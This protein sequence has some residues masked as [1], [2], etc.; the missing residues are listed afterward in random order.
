M[1]EGVLA[2]VLNRFLAEYVDGLNT[3]QLNIGIWSGDV[4][5]RNLR[6]KRTALD[7]FQLPLDVKEGYLGRLTLSIPWS[8]LKS[9]SVRVLVENV[10]LI[11]APRDVDA[12]CEAG[13]E[14]ARMQA[15]KLAKLAQSEL[16]ALPADKPGDEN[17]QKTE[18]FLSSLITRIVDNVQVTVRNIHVRY[19]DAL[20]NPA[21]PF[22]VG[23]T[24]AELS[25][26]STNEHWEPTFVHNS[27][28][29][30]HK[31][32]R[33]D[34]LSVYWDTN[35]TF[36]SASD[37]EEL[38]S[39]LNELL[40]TKDVVPTHQYILKP[41]SGVGKLVMRPKA[42]KEAPKMDAQLVFDQIGV[43]LDDE[44]YRE[45]LSI[46]NL[47]TLYGRQSQYRSLRPA[48]EDLEAN[49]AR[50]RLLFAI[51]AIVNEVHQRRR[52]WTWKH[53]AER[54]DMRRE[55]I[56]LFKI[57]V[58]DAPAQPMPNVWPS[59]MSPEDAEHLRML[60]QCLEYRD[61]RFFRSLARRELRRELAERGPLVQAAE[62]VADATQAAASGV[63]QNTWLGWLW[64][65][66]DKKDQVPALNQEQRKELYEAIDWDETMGASL[67]AALEDTPPDVV[68]LHATAKLSKGFLHLHGHQSGRTL[69]SLMYDTLQGELSQ[70]PHS[71]SASLSLGGICVEDA[72]SLDTQ[73]R[74][75]VR[76]TD[77]GNDSG[78]LF[79]TLFEQNLLDGRADSALQLRMRSTEVVY[80]PS[81]IE[82]IARFF[83]PPET[84]L[85]LIGALIDV[86]S[87][88]LEG[89]RRETRAGLENALENHRTVDLS[90]DVQAP[91]IVVPEDLS[92]HICQNLVLDAGH[93][94]V[95]SLLVSPEALSEVRAKHHRQYTDEDMR[96][97]EDLMYDRYFIKLEAAQLVLGDSYEASMRSIA[98]TE[99]ERHLHLFERINLSFTLHTSILPRAPNLTR[100][101]LTGH[102]PSLYIH[103]S[104]RK[105]RM[106][107]HMIMLAIP[108]FDVPAVDVVANERRARIAEQLMGEGDLVADDTSETV[109]SE[110]DDHVDVSTQQLFCFELV[111]DEVSGTVSKSGLPDKL[112]AEAVF[113]H[114]MLGVYIFSGKLQVDVTLGSLD[115]VDKVVDQAPAFRHMITSRSFE[116]VTGKAEPPERDA[117][118]L[119]LVQYVSV[120]SDAP[121]FEAYGGIE[122][123][124]NVELSTINIMVTRVSVL[125]V[126]DWIL[127]T[128]AGGD[129]PQ[130]A[131]AEAEAPAAPATGSKFRLKVKLSSVRVRLND[132]GALLSTLTLS[133]AT[134]ALLLRGSTMRLAARLGSLSLRDERERERGETDFA[135]LLSI[136]G[137][138]LVDFAME[139]FD[140]RDAHYPGYDTSLWLRCNTLKLMYIPEPFAELV[141]F[142]SKFAEMKAV[143]DAATSAASAQASHLQAQQ[144]MTRYDVLVR[145]PIVVMPRAMGTVDRLTAHL[146][147]LYA[148]NSFAPLSRGYT[149]TLDAGLRQIRL[150]SHMKTGAGVAKLSMLKDV[151]VALKLVQDIEVDSADAEADAPR[152]CR[153]RFSSELSHVSA[154][155][156]YEQYQLA[157]SILRKLSATNAA[158]DADAAEAESDAAN[159][160]AK[161]AP[162]P[163]AVP[164]WLDGEFSIDQVQLDLFDEHAKTP[165]LLRSSQLFQFK[166]NEM[167][168]KVHQA[169]RQHLEAELAIRSFTAT[170][171]RPSRE[172]HFREI[173]PA[174]T[175]DGQQLLLNYTQEADGDALA[176]VTIDSPKLIFSLDP[177]FA[178]VNFLA[179][180]EVES[181]KAPAAT[182]PS[183]R[184]LSFRVNIVE[185]RIILLSAP[186][187]SD[188]QAIV[189][190][191][192]QA[193]ISQQAVLALSMTRLG[194]FVW[195]MNAP[196]D[197]QR[198]LNDVDVSLTMD[199]KMTPTGQI[200]S[201]QV[202]VDLLLVRVTRS[203]LML[204][205]TVVNKAI[206][207]SSTEKAPV[208]AEAPAVPA[209]LA[210]PAP[211]APDKDS[212]E[213][214]FSREE[215]IVSGAGVQVMLISE[216]QMLPLLDLRLNAYDVKA[217]DWSAD[218]KVK[219]ALDVRLNNFNLASS[220]WEPM[221]EPWVLDVRYERFVTPPSSSF[222]LSSRKR[223]EMNVSAQM[224]ETTSNMLSL[225]DQNH[226]LREDA[227][228]MAPFRIR[229]RTGY[230]LS[231]WN[232]SN[233]A[234]GSGQAGSA[235][236][237]GAGA[238]PRHSA[239]RLEDGHDMPWM[240]GDWKSLRENPNEAGFNRLAVHVDSMPWERVRHIDVD[241]EGEYVMS[242]RPKLERVAH[243]LLCDVKLVNNVKVITFQSTFRVDN[244]ALIPLEVGVLNDEGHIGDTVL[245]IEP[246][247]DSALPILSAYY[248]RIRVRP[249]PGLGYGWSQEAVGWQ[250]LL[251]GASHTFTCP[252]DEANEAPFLFQA[253][254][255]CDAETTSAR[256]YPQVTL[257][258]RAPVEIEN[259][260]PY[261]VHYRLFDKNLNHNWASFLRRGGISPVHVVALQ[262][263]LLLSVDIEDSVYSPSE[264]AIIA[265]DNPDDFQV[266]HVLPLADASN[267][268][269]ELRLHYHTY[270]DSGG[271][272][273]VQ[274]YAPYIFLNQTQL[275]VTLKMRPWAGHTRMVAGQEASSED[276]IEAHEPRRPFLL[277]R[278]RERN[279]RFVVRVGDSA[280]SRPLSFDV[281]GSEVGVAIQSESGDRELQLGLDVEDGLGKFKLSKI[282]KLTPRYMVHNSLRETL[283]IAEDGGG[284]PLTLAPDALVPLHWLHV[285]STRHCVL[286]V[287]DGAWSA[288][289]NIDN[290]GKVYVRVSQPEEQL[291]LRLEVQISGPSIFLRVFPMLGPW[292]YLLRN[293]TEHTVAFMQTTEGTHDPKRYVLK[294]RSKMKYAWDYPAEQEKSL[295]LQINGTE[296]VV[297]IL[298]IGSLL[299]FRFGA[300]GES[301]GGVVSLDVRADGETHTLVISDYAEDKSN[302]KMTCGAR[303]D[304]EA[305]DVDTSILFAFN[306]ELEG[307]GIS[308]V[309]SHMIE[310][311]YVTFRGVEFSFSE[312]Q[313]TTAVN[314]I[315]KWIQI[316][317]QTVESLFP[318][319]LYPTIVP[320][321][322]KELEVHPT[323]QAS[324]I[325]SKDESHGVRHIKYASVLLQE[326]TAELDE[327]F[328]FAVY[329]FVRASSATRERE[330][331]ETEY[332]ENPDHVPEPQPM[333]VRADQIYIEILHLQP[334]ALNLSYM[335][336]DRFDSSDAENTRTLFAFF[337]NMLTM[338]LGNVNEAPVR[339][340]ALV[341]ENVR[342]SKTVLSQRITYHYG[343]E[344]LFQVHR[345]LG[346]ADF[347]GN[348][349]GLFNNVSSGVAD[350]FYEPYYGLVMHGNRELGYGIARGASNFVKKTVFGVT[351]SV[352]KL[353]GSISKG[354]AAVTLDREFQSRWR[355]T[356][357]RN[358]PKHALYGI[359]SGANS[360]F[361]SVASGIEGLALRPLEGA[362]E[363]GASGFIQGIGRG[364]VGA[365]TKP[366]AGF[367]DMASSIT[368]GLRNTTLVF[369][370]NDIVRVRLP[371]FIANDHILRPYDP[372]EALGQDW[373][374]AVDQGR[375]I[376]DA[377][378]AHVETPGPRG[379][380]TVMLTETR[381]R[382]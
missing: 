223:L 62:G 139:T 76:V 182:V 278:A 291:L 370:Q 298:E 334:M 148:H 70:R 325:Q 102:L 375:L 178:L 381:I 307:V 272:F 283:R 119:V 276:A 126:Y 355:M 137:H 26:V 255:L 244:R 225:L 40:P 199:L 72:T 82:A 352:S 96:Q 11:A 358:K 328:L 257:A 78:P 136:E 209:T 99:H 344:F 202:S 315:C 248:G 154:M 363:N 169:P 227:R 48:P 32:A 132:D 112:L 306:V 203:D 20:S 349:V 261:D 189:L 143:Y 335:S 51:R 258:L 214:L 19:E 86:A 313:V 263:L 179:L 330:H 247:T 31:L 360:L 193:V 35:A 262:H 259:L 127:S 342:M 63:Q 160:V 220:Y 65:S 294:P 284:D 153:M 101:R 356:H 157:M 290:I 105:Y 303:D 338:V 293:E 296:R 346:S 75:I 196:K 122:Q 321:D 46:V 187:R 288:P 174:I 92:T 118:N 124:V 8:N 200:T 37:P 45:G 310:I 273:K 331:N 175:H 165:E 47:F 108:T 140:E 176:I 34:S 333:P 15:V 13:E 55:Y 216:A 245:R 177:L 167:R 85:E 120:S 66:P 206:A 215:L 191:L 319:V 226:E 100:C 43:I 287:G 234:G 42:T 144:G 218:M 184:K 170:D 111:V 320:K 84:D 343:Q 312:S 125:T 228:H 213:I 318:I 41:V 280:W 366:A 238:G 164:V 80:H 282:V 205:S 87:S 166:L 235:A 50:A 104:D 221:L 347:L 198:L 186:E 88:T 373:L 279:N 29:G 5:L 365:V 183:E 357:F 377:Y 68:Q 163:V 285:A 353:T 336:T 114:F 264:F 161:P 369:E 311:A 39:L 300:Q 121:D 56:R 239:H 268:K 133:T 219:T 211:S 301:R 159:A 275:P 217:T 231:V 23:I 286:A 18:S 308:F 57:V 362:E 194:I 302:F 109:L 147:E 297:N 155:L 341:I 116:E 249:E 27:V 332:I 16:L 192:R 316:D 98:G 95:R 59:T 173:V 28:L 53:I 77:E 14:D 345:I 185:P 351:D 44:Q 158:H 240:F 304:F 243:R 130:E 168:V 376:R 64:G 135:D 197:R 326:M 269:L 21:C 4:T 367:F 97:L 180:P 1:L 210:S 364:L 181:P 254:A 123:H 73:Y 146:G 150:D 305:V 195:R 49:R 7:K 67:S 151:H 138:E 52:V 6:L 322:G 230:R 107:L 382:T 61:I 141:A 172:T 323:L 134:I 329:D 156:T 350:I 17:S 309:S 60:E 368:E 117:H 242:L 256:H 274:I 371:R 361:T 289:F 22:A 229:N 131:P 374:R 149:S 58:G 253:F 110:R 115:L 103:F 83:Q 30:I 207:L 339:L 317:N 106:L 271:A 12:A 113:K 380:A 265:S 54:R 277:S 260:L 354:F 145:S 36:L 267:L 295:C 250:D 188:S 270:P 299:P 324:I 25:A 359:T 281:I 89:L 348:P 212:G 24:L 378:V 201:V 337:F 233:E 252:A 236:G 208:E 246:G 162:V 292:P 93:L 266:E 2:S 171:T 340:N 33:L 91:V 94:A 9:K 204:L 372:R 327:D 224:V 190:M 314:L 379:G 10:S 90:L 232:E 74:Q 128:F 71:F 237:A 38:Q 3:S 222:T 81:Y 142:F 152:Q 251:L 129:E 241:R 69:F 79:F